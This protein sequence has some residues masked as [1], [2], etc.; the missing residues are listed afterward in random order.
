MP[1]I[2]HRSLSVL[3]LVLPL[4][5]NLPTAPENGHSALVSNASVTTGRGRA[6]DPLGHRLSPP[7]AAPAPL[8]SAFPQERVP[9]YIFSYRAGTNSKAVTAEL[10]AT[11]GFTPTFVYNVVPGFAAVVSEQALAGIRCDSRIEFVEY[12]VSAHLAK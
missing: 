2:A 12:D 10:A 6:L 11:Y 8:R 9:G 4:G 3:A 5:C 1:P 7:C